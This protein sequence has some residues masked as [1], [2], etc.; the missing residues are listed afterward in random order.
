MYTLGATTFSRM[1]LSGIILRSMTQQND[2]HRIYSPT[3]NRKS[4]LLFFIFNFVKCVILLKS[5]CTILTT[6][7]ATKWQPSCLSK[8]RRR[9]PTKSSSN[10]TAH[11]RHLCRKTMVLSCH[12]CLIDTGVE[13]NEQYLNVE[14][15]HWVIIEY[16]ALSYFL[17]VFQF[18]CFKATY[19]LCNKTFYDRN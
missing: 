14:N 1:T 18:F 7:P 11:I 4:F 6:L 2:T 10:I 9:A 3:L 12:R 8:K 16:V 17:S 5:Y 13:K 15:Y 19:I